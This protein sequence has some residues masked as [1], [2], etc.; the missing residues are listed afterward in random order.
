MSADAGLRSHIEALPDELLLAVLAWLGAADLCRA[1][2]CSRRMRDICLD[3][4]IWRRLCF[5]EFGERLKH[6][7][8]EATVDQ[9]AGFWHSVFV[10]NY[11]DCQSRL[12][13][14]R[15]LMSD[16]FLVTAYTPREAG[17]A[18]PDMARA[19]VLGE[20]ERA[21]LATH[22]SQRH[23]YRV[24][25]AIGI[26]GLQDL[27]FA[28]YPTAELSLSRINRNAVRIVNPNNAAAGNA[29]GAAGDAA[30]LDAAGNAAHAG[31]GARSTI[32]LVDRLKPV[33]L[34]LADMLHASRSSTLGTVTPRSPYALQ[35]FATC[36]YEHFRGF[37]RMD[38]DQQVS[39]FVRSYWEVD[40]RLAKPL[41]AVALYCTAIAVEQPVRRLASAAENA[42]VS[43]S[44]SADKV[45]AHAMCFDPLVSMPEPAVMLRHALT[46][47]ADDIQSL[48]M[49]VN[50][51]LTAHLQGAIQQAMH[52][53]LAQPLEPGETDAGREEWRAQASAELQRQ[54][55]A[56]AYAL[57]V[58]RP[59]ILATEL[60]PLLVH[61][62]RLFEELEAQGKFVL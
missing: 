12:D 51:V 6:M 18:A 55:A 56:L 43:V 35:F 4:S 52:A 61:L 33:P 45:N 28:R 3:N 13:K 57:G 40:V 38:N 59:R 21:L 25:T 15:Y 36:K 42:L 9:A 44:T 5:E 47:I 26:A 22:T 54:S 53:V 20:D 1:C 39:P 31:A 27:L 23:L 16:H 46:T 19:A 10:S 2:A 34:G 37:L 29:A 24:P 62:E 60:E 48:F 8:V 50:S 32:L 49:S 30:H 7:S 14:Q 41:P 17:A 11:N 58:L